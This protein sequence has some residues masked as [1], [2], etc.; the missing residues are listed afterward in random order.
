MIA[1]FTHRAM[2]NIAP[3]TTELPENAGV[4]GSTYGAQVAND[5][6][7][8]S[9]DGPCPPPQYTPKVHH[10]VFTV[11]ALDVELPTLPSFGAFPPGAEG[12]YHALIRAGR[13][14]HILATASID[15]FFPGSD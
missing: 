14:G 2:Y 13:Y 11:Y 4:A 15:G 10:Y 8:L 9:Y 12:L 3:T 5:F 1:S 6:G 7:D